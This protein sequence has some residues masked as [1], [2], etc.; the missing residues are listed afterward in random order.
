MFALREN[1]SAIVSSAGFFEARELVFDELR[2]DRFGETLPS[3]ERRAFERLS[4]KA[5]AHRAGLSVT[6]D[7]ARNPRVER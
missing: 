5:A 6:R 4:Q 3:G 2:G 1:H 7:G